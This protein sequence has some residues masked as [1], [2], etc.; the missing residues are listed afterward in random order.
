MANNP[1]KR[2]LKVQIEFETGSR[3]SRID[4]YIINPDFDRLTLSFPESKKEFIPYL[5]E[6][7]EIKAFIYT[8]SGI[9]II[10]SIVFDAPFDGKFVIE[11]N[12]DQQVIQRRKYLRQPYMTDLYLESPDGNI[13]TMTIDIGGGG[14]RFS[15]DK[16][17]SN[18]QEFKSQ[19]RLNAYEPMIKIIGFVQKKHF[20]KDD[21][22]LFEFTQIAESDRN[23]IIQKCIQLEREQNKKY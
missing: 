17:I 22:Y 13:R 1:I 10:D 8:F 18:M 14:I 6:G 12:E 5:I 9:M 11:F 15:T 20:Y 21:E 19:L 23:K 4:C 2:G 7:T 16:V 3:K